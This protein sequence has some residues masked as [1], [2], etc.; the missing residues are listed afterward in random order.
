MGLGLATSSG[1]LIIV[2]SSVLAGIVWWLG[3]QYALSSRA[4]ISQNQPLGINP[5]LIEATLGIGMLL[6]TFLTFSIRSV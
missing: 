1:S 6:L 2:G 3:T 5:I 4:K